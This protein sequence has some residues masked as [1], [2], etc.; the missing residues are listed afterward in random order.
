[1][2]AH[3]VDT[4]DAVDRPEVAT[5]ADDGSAAERFPAPFWV[6]VMEHASAAPGAR[7]FAI[8]NGA[9]QKKISIGW[10]ASLGIS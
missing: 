8:E 4:Y 6:L 3:Q 7:F 5:H 1:M 10:S 9:H 2:L